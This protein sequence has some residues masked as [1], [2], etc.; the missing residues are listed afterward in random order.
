MADVARDVTGQVRTVVTRAV[1]E[2]VPRV[3]I[4]RDRCD[5]HRAVLVAEVVRF[6]DNRCAD[7]ARMRHAPVDIG[8]L[9]R[10]V[11]DAVAVLGQAREQGAVGLHR[12]VEHEPRRAADEDEGV[13]IA[14]PGGRAGIGHELHAVDQLEVRRRLRRV[15]DR[16]HQGIPAGDR[17]RVVAGVVVDEADELPQLRRAQIREPFLVGEGLLQRHSAIQLPRHPVGKPSSLN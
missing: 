4:G 15:A 13:M 1:D 6:V 14:Q 17:E 11:A 10:D 12:A 8:D 2:G 16:P 5:T 3:A 7:L 9:E